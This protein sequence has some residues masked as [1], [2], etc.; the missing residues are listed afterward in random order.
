MQYFSST[1]NTTTLGPGMD[2][3]LEMMEQYFDESSKRHEA[4]SKLNEFLIWE[5]VTG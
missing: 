3:I 2:S 1:Y 5:F 4:V